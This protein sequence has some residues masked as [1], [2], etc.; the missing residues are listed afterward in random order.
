MTG[1]EADGDRQ[2]HD[3]DGF[4]K[5]LEDN[6]NEIIM[7]VCP[8]DQ[9]M[10]QDTKSM[11]PLQDT[12]G[13]GVID[14]GDTE[15]VGSLDV[16]DGLMKLRVNSKNKGALVVL[17]EGKKAFRFG[18]GQVQWAPSADLAPRHLHLASGE[19]P[20]PSGHEDD[21]T[22]WSSDRCSRNFDQH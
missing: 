1:A 6:V 5:S 8:L 21:G 9:M 10:F 15:T 22:P 7:Q 2:W 13:F 17:P 4:G 11:N 3:K 12:T 16:L 14:L 18:N 20:H 19:S